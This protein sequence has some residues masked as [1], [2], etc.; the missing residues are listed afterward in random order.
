MMDPR[1]KAGARTLYAWLKS[2]RMSVGEVK[3]ESF[4]KLLEALAGSVLL[5]GAEMRGCW[6]HSS[7]YVRC[8]QPAYF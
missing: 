5:Y 3:G 8:G 2:C 1:A 6:V 7:N 4:V